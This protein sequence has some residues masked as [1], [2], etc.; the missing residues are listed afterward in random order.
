[1]PLP[2]EFTDDA[3][4][5]RFT[6][7]YRSELRYTA[8][9]SKWNFWDGRRWLQ[10]STLSV[11][12]RARGICRDVAPLCDDKRLAQRLFSAQAVSAV[13]RLARSDRAH[14][15]MPEQWDADSWLLN[16]P[17]G[18]VDLRT[19]KSWGPRVLLHIAR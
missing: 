18:I 12:D 11:Q 4:A 7:Q 2:P 19:G 5:R 1:M 8:Q 17:S 3:L 14:A 15:M 10:D 6:E 13:E 9:W 16:T